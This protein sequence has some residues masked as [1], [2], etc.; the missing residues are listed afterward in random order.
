[1]KMNIMKGNENQQK[2]TV[3]LKTY[4]QCR[5]RKI[6]NIDNFILAQYLILL[7][8]AKYNVGQY[9][10]RTAQNLLSSF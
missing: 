4:K 2:V 6:T 9:V 3:N 10:S 7:S 1:M 8:T 5:E